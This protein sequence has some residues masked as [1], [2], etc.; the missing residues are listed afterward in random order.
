[1]A[2]CGNCGRPCRLGSACGCGYYNKDPNADQ[3]F[4]NVGVP[5]LAFL[6]VGGY[7][8]Y[9]TTNWLYALLA[10]VGAALF[11]KT[12]FGRIVAALVLGGIALVITFFILDLSKTYRR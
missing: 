11:A 4:R 5:E 12:G 2:S 9:E 1:M 8:F 6:V 3:A 10:G 7:V